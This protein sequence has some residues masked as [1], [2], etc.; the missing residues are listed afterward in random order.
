[1]DE[2]PYAETLE[3]EE[4]LEGLESKSDEEMEELPKLYREN[5]RDLSG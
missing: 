4:L 5:S 3:P 2:V 1:M